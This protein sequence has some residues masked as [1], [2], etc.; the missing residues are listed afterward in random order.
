ML[1]K[2]MFIISIFSNGFIIIEAL[3]NLFKKDENEAMFERRIKN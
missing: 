1:L 3:Y 2:I